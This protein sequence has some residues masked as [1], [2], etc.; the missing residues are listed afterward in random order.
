MRG[1]RR[2]FDIVLKHGK[3]LAH[4]WRVRHHL[5]GDACDV[6]DLLADGLL[7]VDERG[8][9]IRNFAPAQTHCADFRDAAKPWVQPRCFKIRITS[10][11]VCYTKLLRSC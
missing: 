10:Y 8:E 6:R 3:R 2:V 9:R 11:N 5:V 7:G 1:K 4:L